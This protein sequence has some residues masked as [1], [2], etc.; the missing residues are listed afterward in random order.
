MSA[1]HQPAFKSSFLHYL[2]LALKGF[3][4]GC[5]D[6]A[7][8]VSGGTMAFILGIYR[9]LIK[10]I[11][12][13]DLTFLKLL[14]ALKIRTA[15][16]RTA[17]RFLLAVGGGILAAVFTMARVVSWLLQNQ[18]VMVW[19]FF[20]GLIAASVLTVSRYLTA[21]R[22]AVFGWIILGAA[23]TY[24]LVGLVP[25]ATPETNWFL[26]LSGAVAICA[27]ILPG[28]SG[29]FILVLLG[30]YYYVLEAV[31]QRDILILFWVTAG[32][33]T[34]LVAF[35][36]LLNW[37]FNRYHNFAIA[38]L[39][40]LMLGSLRKIW[41]WKEALPDYAAAPRNILPGQ[42][43]GEV[44]MAFGWAVFAFLLVLLL[45]SLAKNR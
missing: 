15:L 9:E 41:P 7:P 43:N 42:L 4:M 24:L 1:A 5:A 30:K 10:A 44:A 40:G 18:P 17:W 6:V 36:R 33:G 32:A 22:P 11:R 26:F 23:A 31:N 19:S 8:G 14:A 29:A 35:S 45:D 27:M 12:S 20:F 2:G 16:E 34:G 25:A 38:L 37:L 39:T 21:R 13:F 3:C 28:I